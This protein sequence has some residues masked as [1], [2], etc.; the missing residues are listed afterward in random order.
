M[1]R[2]GFLAGSA[3]LMGVPALA[4]AQNDVPGMIADKLAK[5]ETVFLDFKA[6]WCST[7]K[8]QERVMTRLKAGTRHMHKRSA[9]SRWIELSSQGPNLRVGCRFRAARRSLCSRVIE[10]LGGLWR[11]Q[12][13][14]RF[15]R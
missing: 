8:A 2:R 5:G 6:D 15:V 7:C 3:A 1:K 10:S 13:R 4:S 11:I 14:R 9:F 12:A